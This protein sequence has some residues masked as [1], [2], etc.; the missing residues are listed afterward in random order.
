MHA[1]DNKDRWIAT[2]D[3]DGRKLVN[4]HRATDDAWI[5]PYHRGHGWL[6]DNKTLWFLSEDH[7]YLGIY[8]KGLDQRRSRAAVAG[9][10]VVFGPVLGPS[11]KFIYYRANV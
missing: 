2:V 8:T 10:H 4:Q 5:N 7:G 3:F 9:E 1:N 6:K 11:G